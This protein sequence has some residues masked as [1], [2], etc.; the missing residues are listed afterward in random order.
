MYSEENTAM[1]PPAS[2]IRPPS[3]IPAVTG[4][5]EMSSS[6]TNAR[7]MGPPPSSTLKHKATGLP[8]PEPDRKRKTLIERAGEAHKSGP[9]TNSGVRPLSASFKTSGLG[10]HRPVTLNSSRTNGN[11]TRNISGGSSTSSTSTRPPSAASNSRS[12]SSMSHARAKSQDHGALARSTTALAQREDDSE[13]N[14]FPAKRKAWDTAGRLEDMEMLYA[15]LKSTLASAAFEKKGVEDNLALYKTR[16]NELEQMRLQ[17]TASNKTISDELS[18]VKVKLSTASL[19]LDDTRR[20]HGQ[21]IDDLIRKHRNQDDDRDQSHRKE[22]ERMRREERDEKDRL[23][24]EMQD[25][26]ERLDRLKR[27][28]L[29]DQERALKA[30]IDDERSKR[31]R[32]I[33]EL[34]MQHAIERQ[35]TDTDLTKRD[36]DMQELRKELDAANADLDSANTQIKNMRDKLAEASTNTLSLETSMKALRAKIDFLESDNQAQSQAFADLHQK[37][38]DAVDKA[39]EAQEKLRA[40]ETLRRKLHNQ[41]QELK[42]NI[43]VFCRVRPIL[44]S[45]EDD[46]ARIGFPDTD[47]DSKEV[48]IQSDQKSATGNIT[49][50]TSAFSFD[51]VFAPSSQNGEVFEEISQLIQ[52]ALD[53]YN[54]CIF[55]YGQTGSGKTHTMS[56]AD[57]MIPRAVAQIYDTAKSLEEKGWV[58]KMEGSFIEVYNDT[59]NDLLGKAEDWEKKKHEIKHDAARQRTTVTDV[60]MVPLDSPTRV[61]AILEKAGRNRS[62]AATKANSRSSRSHSVFILKLTGEN[63][64]T[65]EKSEGT[66]NLVDLAG[67]ERLSHSGATGD[68]MKETQHI[69]KSL[70]CLG[71]VI[72]ALGQGK[73]GG[74]VPYRNSKLTYLLQYSLGGNSKTLM[75][76]MISPLQAHLGETLTSLKFATKVHNTHI[77]TAKRQTRT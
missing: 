10:S 12:Q 57:G 40:E 66:L 26:L 25:E 47:G 19:A 13:L 72:G 76:V 68:R 11:A 32:E 63:S 60:T 64:I 69:N 54:V 14:G 21:E 30:E 38:Q 36:R 31:L 43:R 18:D 28:E 33:Q 61:N 35:S 3:R 59:L 62:V 37:M 16:I 27:E 23:R 70:A 6:D 9:N 74:H 20:S 8:V 73:E 5:L 55:C 29:A 56:S 46:K 22:L 51:R 50:S 4:L 15:D 53:G 42:G 48:A 39:S 2:G 67:S 77:G 58:Y 49:T 52:S 45:D 41:V 44:E 65:G 7:S 71:D 24:K 34:T 75:F 17:L 1:R